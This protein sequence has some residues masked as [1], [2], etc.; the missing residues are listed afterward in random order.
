MPKSK[1]KKPVKDTGYPFDTGD[2]D[3]W[4]NR[5]RLDWA[6]NFRDKLRDQYKET[7][8]VSDEQIEK[9]TATVDL[10]Q[11][12]VDIEESNPEAAP[13][14]QDRSPWEKLEMRRA[15]LDD[16]SD[17]DYEKA[18]VVGWTEE[19]VE[20][21]KSDL[22]KWEVELKEWKRRED[23]KMILGSA[24]NRP[25]T[26]KKL[27]PEDAIKLH[28]LLAYRKVDDTKLKEA[29]ASEDEESVNREFMA[30]IEQLEAIADRDP[31]FAKWFEEFRDD[32]EK[33]LRWDDIIGDE[34][35]E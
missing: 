1:N 4:S 16:L 32:Q 6:V 27:D 28:V 15:W 19:N 3:K 7:L 12:I 10:L 8:N 24:S 13:D 22:D 21:M 20:R 26:P 18:R 17:N 23:A 29:I 31:I 9:Y 14:Y 35:D 30:W 33:L 34:D 2:W 11:K 5:K 25:A